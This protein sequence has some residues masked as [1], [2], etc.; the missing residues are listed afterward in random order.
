M[1]RVGIDCE[2]IIDER[3]LPFLF[4]TGPR[5]MGKYWSRAHLPLSLVKNK[6]TMLKKVLEKWP[7]SPSLRA[8]VLSAGGLFKVWARFDAVSLSERADGTV[9]KKK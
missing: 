9:Y 2:R 6:G 7:I 8:K 4:K 5:L 1:R 3:I